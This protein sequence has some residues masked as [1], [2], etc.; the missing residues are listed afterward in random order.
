[1]EL[2]KETVWKPYIQGTNK[3]ALLLDQIHPSFIDAVDSLGTQ[4]IQI[5]GGFTFIS[6]SCDVGIIKSFKTRLVELCQEWKVAEYTRK[7]ETGKVPVPGSI[8]MLQWLDKIWREFP[9]DIILNSFKKCGFTDELDI[10]I[11]IALELV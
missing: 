7:G 9:S 2:W 11:H 1:M 10:E 5:P 3:S 6:Q 8:Q 4:V